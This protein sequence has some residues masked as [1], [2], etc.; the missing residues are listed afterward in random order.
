ME[1]SFNSQGGPGALWSTHSSG[2]Y[3][4]QGQREQYILGCTGTKGTVVY[5][6]KGAVYRGVGKREQYKGVYTV[7][8]QREQYAGGVGTKGAV[9]RGVGTKGAVY[10]GCSIEEMKA[11]YHK[12]MKK[13][14]LLQR[15]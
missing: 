4:V 6:T 11:L 5:R 14:I 3:T 7:Q 15:I 9:Y 12:N 10:R 1:T 8:G 2:V 13:K